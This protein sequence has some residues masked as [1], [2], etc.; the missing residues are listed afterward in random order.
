MNPHTRRVRG[1]TGRDGL[2]RGRLLDLMEG[3]VDNEKTHGVGPGM[4][5][6]GRGVGAVM[7][8]WKEV[9]GDARVVDGSA[10]MPAC[11]I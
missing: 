2:W 8:I 5:S 7:G 9:T 10:G 11:D 6:V 1:A 4:G 3:N